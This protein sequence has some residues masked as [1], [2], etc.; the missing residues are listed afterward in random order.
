MASEA[1]RYFIGELYAAD[2]G[3][4]FVVADRRG[5]MVDP[6]LD[7]SA[8]RAIVAAA[9]G[10]PNVTLSPVTLFEITPEEFELYRDA[11]IQVPGREDGV[12]IY[13]VK[14]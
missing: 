9:D 6:K 7:E 3:F 10:N 4:G 1:A 14:R 12:T 5:S 8:A 13:Q 11:E 2:V